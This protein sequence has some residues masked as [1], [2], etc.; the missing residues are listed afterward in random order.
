[1][2]SLKASYLGSPGPPKTGF[3]TIDDIIN[4]NLFSRS[5]LLFLRFIAALSCLEM[6]ILCLA[7]LLSFMEADNEGAFATP[8]LL[9]VAFLLPPAA[10]GPLLEAT[11]V[12]TKKSEA[13]MNTRYFVMLTIPHAMDLP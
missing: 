6:L 4:C 3:F 10:E 8:S 12:S 11:A 13:N 2:A 5:V 1:M 7:A 9:T